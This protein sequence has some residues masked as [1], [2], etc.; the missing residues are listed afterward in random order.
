MN[1]AFFDLPLI[2]SGGKANIAEVGFG[3]GEFLVHAASEYPDGL[4]FGIEISRTCVE[5][6]LKRLVRDKVGNVRIISG[7][8]RFI[9]REV[10]ADESL[11]RIYMSFPCPWPKERHSKRRVTYRGFSDTLGS[12][13]K[14]GGCFELATDEKWYAKEAA[15]ALGSHEA[16]ELISFDVNKKRKITT[17]YERKWLNQGKDIFLLVF[18]KTSDF[19]IER[20]VEGRCR[21]LHVTIEPG[22]DDLSHLNAVSLGLS[23]ENG[24]SHW[25]LDRIYSNGGGVW[26][27]QTITSDDGYEQKFYITVV[28]RE[29][30]VLIKIDGFS[31]PFLTP[32]VKNAVEALSLSLSRP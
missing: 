16:L 5:K 26:L 29:E 1:P 13:L 18:Q 4:V 7:D 31:S 14:K 24:T 11:D 8:A 21:D 28:R 30:G 2:R 3:N 32:A 6:A 12:V 9:L 27:I 15:K 23:G 25:T 19:S 17:K 20:I 22:R 10:F